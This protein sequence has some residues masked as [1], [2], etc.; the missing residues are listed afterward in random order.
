MY[1]KFRKKK[2]RK[3]LRRLFKI[4]IIFTVEYRLKF[5][6]SLKNKKIESLLLY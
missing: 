5:K 3:I 2:N 4:H 6:A 1:N